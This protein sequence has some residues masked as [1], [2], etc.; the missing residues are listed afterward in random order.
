MSDI[1]NKT[2]C[3]QEYEIMSHVHKS[4]IDR[5]WRGTFVKIY[6]AEYFRP[7]EKKNTIYTHRKIRRY[8][9]I[10]NKTKHYSNQSDFTFDF[11]LIKSYSELFIFT[12]KTKLSWRFSIGTKI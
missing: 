8:T 7:E 11:F 3:M 4:M 1:L 5:I 9:I 6:Y 10:H 2:R 12:Y